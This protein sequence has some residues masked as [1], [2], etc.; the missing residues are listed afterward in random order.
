VAHDQTEIEAA[1]MN[2]QA[3]EDIGVAG[4]FLV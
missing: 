1:R 2:Q 3:L 4:A